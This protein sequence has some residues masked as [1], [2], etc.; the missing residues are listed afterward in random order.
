MDKKDLINNI[1]SNKGII[2]LLILFLFVLVLSYLISGPAWD[3]IVHYLNARSYLNSRFYQKDFSSINVNGWEIQ[4]NTFY[5]EPLREAIPSAIFVLLI[6]IFHNPILPYTIVLYL[7]FI[8]SI[9]LFSRS[10]KFDKLLSY[11][12]ILSPFFIYFSLLTNGTEILS[13]SFLLITLGLL[14]KKSPLSGLFLGLAALSKYPNLIFLPLL[15]FAG[16]KKKIFLAYSIFALVTIPWLA[17]NYIFYG[18]P[19][20]AYLSSISLNVTTGNSISIPIIPFL[21]GILIPILFLIFGLSNKFKNIRTLPKELK[22]TL[23]NNEFTKIS[24]LFSGLAVLGYLVITQHTDYF[25]QIRY[26]YLIYTSASLFTLIVLQKEI[27][28]IPK[29]LNYLV[30]LAFLILIICFVSFYHTTTTTYLGQIN[31]NSNTSI[32]KNSVYEL[33]NLGYQGC[34]IESNAWVYLIY[35]NQ[36]AYSPLFLNNTVS[37]EYPI[38]IFNLPAVGVAPSYVWNT[39]QS[40]LVYKNSDYSIFLPR[41]VT[42]IKN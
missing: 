7:I 22:N 16:D 14:Y 35:L 26:S 4:Q 18:N 41:D 31:V 23:K 33:D 10:L 39:N 20:Y 36:S 40:R 37:T 25:G 12:L 15:L 28:S 8:I 30:I 24:I 21:I 9:W 27:K 32:I 11:C 34:R 19:L 13:V 5:I 38:I 1:S 17:F 42:C 6:P 3:V 2:C 29:I